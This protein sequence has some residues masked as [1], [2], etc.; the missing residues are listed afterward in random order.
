MGGLAPAA[1][2]FIRQVA[3]VAEANEVR[4]FAGRDFAAFWIRRICIGGHQAS[5]DSIA[6]ILYKAEAPEDSA[7]FKYSKTPMARVTEFNL[8]QANGITTVSGGGFDSYRAMCASSSA[9]SSS[10]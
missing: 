4:E 2:E 5:A 10:C 7:L 6:D 1:L 9:P 3:K 8:A